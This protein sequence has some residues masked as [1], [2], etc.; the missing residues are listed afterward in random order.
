MS[1]PRKPD[2]ITNFEDVGSETHEAIY[3][4]LRPL[5]AIAHDMEMK[6]GVDR[7]EQLVSPQLAAK[8]GTAKAQLDQAIDQADPAMVAQK[9][10]AMIR[11][12]QA[13]DQAAAH[14][15][16][17]DQIAEAWYWKHPETNQSYAVT[18]DN[19]SAQAIRRL[20]PAPI[21]YTMDEVCRILTCNE[22]AM[23]DKVKETFPNATVVDAGP[24]DDEPL[25]DEIPF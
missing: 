22:M 11:G 1:E 18:K 23:V 9:A 16:T 8:F 21:I 7:L 25:N 4:S 15:M 5:D 24:K 12:W 17:I 2:R 19:A 14:H 3:R 13:L 6:W 20:S 10:S